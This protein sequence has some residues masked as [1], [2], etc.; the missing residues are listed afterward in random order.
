METFVLTD[1]TQLTIKEYNG[2]RHVTL[3]CIR[4]AHS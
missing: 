4:A 2:T 3:D 1:G